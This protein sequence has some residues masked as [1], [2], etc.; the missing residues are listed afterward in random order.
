MQVKQSTEYDSTK[1]KLKFNY[2]LVDSCSSLVAIVV[3]D[4]PLRQPHSIQDYTVD[5][6]H[7]RSYMYCIVVDT[8]CLDCYMSDW[9]CNMNMDC[10]NHMQLGM[11]RMRTN[12]LMLAVFPIVDS[13][14]LVDL[15]RAIVNHMLG[16]SCLLVVDICPIEC[17]LYHES[18]L[19]L[20]SLVPTFGLFPCPQ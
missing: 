3:L 4:M 9:M 5:C 8:N 16:S 12:K 2:L 15:P 10:L 1:S 6:I 14:N 17:H 19:L 13:R 7:C 11:D 20:M 18:A